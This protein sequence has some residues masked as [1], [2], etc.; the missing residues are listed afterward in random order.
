MF[1]IISFYLHP[2]HHSSVGGTGQ[3]RAE[4]KTLK[5]PTLP[6]F[7]LIKHFHWWKCYLSQ[8]TLSLP[9]QLC[10]SNSAGNLVWFTLGFGLCGA[11]LCYVYVC[12]LSPC[13]FLLSCFDG[14]ID[15]CWLFTVEGSSAWFGRSI[16]FSLD[17]WSQRDS[18]LIHFSSWSGE[19]NEWGDWL[20]WEMIILLGLPEFFGKF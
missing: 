7:S 3:L 17:I 15:W 9:A 1:P 12:L 20:R 4:E 18:G 5:F 19:W 16:L 6:L 8:G 2:S 10:W 13:S 14:W 11:V